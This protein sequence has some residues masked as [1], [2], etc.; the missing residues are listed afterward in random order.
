M[1]HLTHGDEA[2]ELVAT[3]L[4]GVLVVAVEALV[5]RDK[6]EQDALSDVL[7]RATSAGHR[8][9]VKHHYERTLYPPAMPP[10]SA[11][12]MVFSEFGKNR[13]LMIIFPY[14]EATFT[15]SLLKDR[16]SV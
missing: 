2:L 13:S 3:A 9:S 8:A 12:G 6:L 11:G 7:R 15:K 5:I 16:S 10:M 14:M 1:G 4:H